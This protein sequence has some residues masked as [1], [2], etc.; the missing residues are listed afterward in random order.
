VKPEGEGATHAFTN[1][2]TAYSKYR[3]LSVERTAE[4][5]KNLAKNIAAATAAKNLYVTRCLPSVKKKII[6]SQ[7]AN[8]VSLGVI[9]EVCQSIEK[10]ISP[11]S[12]LLPSD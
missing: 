5:Q 6:S 11:D 4:S 12:S 2:G 3:G 8:R 1:G 9:N 10:T 7:Q